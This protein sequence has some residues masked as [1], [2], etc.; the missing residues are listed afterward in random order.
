MLIHQDC[1]YTIFG[2]M[3]VVLLLATQPI[4]T[5][6]LFNFKILILV[7]SAKSCR[8]VLYCVE[9]ILL[10]WDIP[11]LAIKAILHFLSFEI[12]AGYS[13]K[14][15]II[16]QYFGCFFGAKFSLVCHASSKTR[17]VS[18]VLELCGQTQDILGRKYIWVTCTQLLWGIWM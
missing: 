12:N 16:S 6:S 3:W 13:N 14:N 10:Y 11:F 7:L 18:L 4:W 1:S 17:N 9:Q 15:L 8:V 5:F 2:M